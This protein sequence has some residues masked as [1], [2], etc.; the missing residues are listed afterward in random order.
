MEMHEKNLKRFNVYS[1]IA[2]VLFIITVIVGVLALIFSAV[3]EVL[4]ITRGDQIMDFVQ[5]AI[6][7][8]GFDFILPID[9]IPP[10]LVLTL[11]LSGLMGIALTA[12]LLREVSKLFKNIVKTKTPFHSNSIKR[13]RGM[14]I[15]LFI[16]TGVQFILSILMSAQGRLLLD[17]GRMSDGFS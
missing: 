8:R 1:I 4:V 6:T 2:K 15:S 14:G 11:I 7:N 10:L 13:I 12:Y 17:A 5:S 3:V 16:F 9:R